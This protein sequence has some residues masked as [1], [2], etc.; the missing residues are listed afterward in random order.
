MPDLQTFTDALGPAAGLVAFLI[1]MLICG[2]FTAN[3]IQYREAKKEKSEKRKLLS[4]FLQVIALISALETME[5]VEIS[6]RLSE[7]SKAA[8]GGEQ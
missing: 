4:G 8:I 1:A 5:K 6:R 7:I 3:A 2:L